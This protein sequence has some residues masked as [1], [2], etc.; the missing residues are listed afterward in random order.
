[1]AVY[2]LGKS[3][4]R[5]RADV[6]WFSLDSSGKSLKGLRY[7]EEN[8]A[9]T[10]PINTAVASHF[11]YQRKYPLQVRRFYNADAASSLH[12]VISHYEPDVIQIESVFLAT[13]IEGLRKLAMLQ[14]FYVFIISRKRFGKIASRAFEDCIMHCIR[15]WRTILDDL[16]AWRG[17]VQILFYPY[18]LPIKWFG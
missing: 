14:S 1:M 13:Y 7:D 15:K 18:L 4:E 12:E 16:N 6:V 8:Q 3:L 5:A 17:L 11:S 9:Y 2:T 10:M